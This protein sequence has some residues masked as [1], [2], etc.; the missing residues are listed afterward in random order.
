MLFGQIGLT[1]RGN[2]AYTLS[3]L[4]RTNIAELAQLC[5][6][7]ALTTTQLSNLFK[8]EFYESIMSIFKI[9][10]SLCS[11]YLLWDYY[12]FDIEYGIIIFAMR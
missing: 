9:F 6:S 7:I 5:I 12:I 4:A 1:K 8:F 10:E 11:K 2:S 3:V